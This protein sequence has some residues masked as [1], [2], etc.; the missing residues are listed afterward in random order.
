MPKH[1]CKA[2]I[3]HQALDVRLMLLQPD[4]PPQ[5]RNNFCAKVALDIHL[6]TTAALSLWIMPR[7]ATHCILAHISLAAAVPMHKRLLT[8]QDV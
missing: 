7:P 4:E 2:P 5:Q 8:F 1:Q 3:T 6:H